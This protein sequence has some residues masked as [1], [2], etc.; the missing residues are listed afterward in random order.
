MT[1]SITHPGGLNHTSGVFPCTHAA[2]GVWRT[3]SL[4][5]MVNKMA[6]E[7]ICSSALGRNYNNTSN[8]IRLKQN[9]DCLKNNGLSKSPHPPKKYSPLTQFPCTQLGK[10]HNLRTPFFSLGHMCRLFLTTALTL[11]AAATLQEQRHHLRVCATPDDG[12]VKN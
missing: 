7:A 8:F 1:I 3:Y 5:T 2:T 11:S 9:I 12:S 4:L 10:L 6:N